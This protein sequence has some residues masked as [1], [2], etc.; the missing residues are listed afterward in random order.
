MTRR[1]LCREMIK[2]NVKFGNLL[3]IVSINA[4]IIGILV[5]LVV[6]VAVYYKQ[7][8]REAELQVIQEA[9]KINSVVFERSAY[10][11]EG[12]K[13]PWGMNIVTSLNM[14]RTKLKI[15]KNI[16]STVSKYDVPV[17]KSD[18]SELYRYLD[19]LSDPLYP[20]GNEFNY[21]IGNE[22]YIPRDGA[23][24]GEEIMIVVNYLS[25]ADIFPESAFPSPLAFKEGPQRQIYFLRVDDVKNWLIKVETFVSGFKKHKYS[26]TIFPGTKFIDSLKSRDRQLIE[27]W[28]ASPVRRSF[29]YLDPEYLLNDFRNKSEI[30]RSVA[31][32]TRHAYNKYEFLSK[33]YSLFPL[34]VILVA[35][36]IIFIAGVAIPLFNNNVNQY[37]YVHL[38]VT[39]YVLSFLGMLFWLSGK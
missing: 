12:S 23:N 31:D 30:V 27:K 29:G 25:Q 15:K 10:Y 33:R 14:D 38:P 3:T 37:I 26:E 16:E 36:L 21:S 6:A 35:L 24:R 20:Q 8:V 32:N 22:K 39:V 18:I 5:A 9:D 2:M 4:T 1:L 19:F 7:I 11:H 17:S 28:K 34:F 13:S